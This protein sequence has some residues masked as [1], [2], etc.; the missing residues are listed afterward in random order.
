MQLSFQ[1]KSVLSNATMWLERRPAVLRVALLAL[2]LALALITALVGG[3]VAFACPV[4]GGGS[5]C[6][7]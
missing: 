5:G 1:L 7:E 4:G 6:G 2:P 3:D